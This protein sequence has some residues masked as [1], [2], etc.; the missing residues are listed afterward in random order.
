M[1]QHTPAPCRFGRSVLRQGAACLLSLCL[2]PAGATVFSSFV[3]HTND[4]N[5][6][7]LGDG[8]PG[9]MKLLNHRGYDVCVYFRYK[10]AQGDVLRLSKVGNRIPA[11]RQ[12][13]SVTG[14]GESSRSLEIVIENAYHAGRCL[15]LESV[16]H[17]MVVV[18]AGEVQQGPA[19]AAFE[20]DARSWSGSRR[21]I[22]V[23]IR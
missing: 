20:V 21:D 13:L 11:G 1:T 10:N 8:Y 2:L 22:T 17:R 7:L 15:S 4:E 23:H 6:Q 14:P 19:F 12:D 16:A 18:R 9:Q 5:T 3:G